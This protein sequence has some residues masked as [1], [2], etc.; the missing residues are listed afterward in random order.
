MPVTI[1]PRSVLTR[2]DWPT[3]AEVSANPEAATVNPGPDRRRRT[4]S[5]DWTTAVVQPT[6]RFLPGGAA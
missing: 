5:P 3:P 2:T 1:L 6:L 4:A